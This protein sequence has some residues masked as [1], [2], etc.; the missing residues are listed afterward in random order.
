MKASSRPFALAPVALVVAGMF[1]AAPTLRAVAATIHVTT[2][3]QK[4]SSS[5]SGGCSLQEAIYSS[6]FAS[7][8]ALVPAPNSLI[9][10]VNTDCEAGSGDDTIVLMGGETYSMSDPVYDPYNYMGPTATPVI[11]SRIVIEANGATLVHASNAVSFR[12]FSIGS[13]SASRA[14]GTVPGAGSLDIRNAN[15]R[16][17]SVKGGDGTSGGGGGLGAGGAIYIN[18]GTL[19][20]ESTAFEAN[21]AFGGN[22]SPRVLIGS[23]GGGGGGLGGDGGATG[24][25]PMPGQGGGTGGGGGGARGSGADATNRFGGGGGGTASDGVAGQGG[26]LCGGNGGD[27]SGN[28]GADG[29]AGGGGGGG[30]PEGFLVGAGKGGDGGY[31]GGGGGG[32][33]DADGGNGGFGAGGGSSDRQTGGNGGFGGGGGSSFGQPGQALIPTYGGN[34]SQNNSGG[35]AGLGGAIFNHRGTVR[36]YNST[37]SGN[38]AQHGCKGG[39]CNGS[40]TTAQNSGDA[41]AAIFSLN[42]ALSIFSSTITGNQGT[43]TGAGVVAIGARDFD[44]LHAPPPGTFELRNTII[45]GNNGAQE[46]FW[47]GEA[48]TAQGSGNLIVNNGAAGT[49]CPGVVSSS[50]PQLGSLQ[51]NVPGVTKTMMIGDASPAYNAGVAY[52][53]AEIASAPTLATDQRG[54]SRPQFGSFDIGAYEVGC[55]TLAPPASFVQATDPNACNAIVTYPLPTANGACGTVSCS[56][57][58]GSVFALGPTSVACR[59]A[60]GLTAGFTIGVKDTQAPTIDPL[61][62]ARAAL[63]PIDHALVNVGLAGG[64]TSDNCSGSVTSVRVFANED[65]ET[66]TGDGVYSPDA[67]NVAIGT[68]RVRAERLDSGSGRVYLIV[69]TVTDASNNSAFRVANVVVPKSQST[70]DMKTVNNLAAAAV[71]YALSHNGSPPAGYFLVGDGRVIGPKQ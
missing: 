32:G 36:I 40:D 64:A 55:S 27:S 62:V 66:D 60:T 28:E 15:I 11:F 8:I 20:V 24:G 54:I 13:G 68:L 46:C 61:S 33:A 1:F 26:F 16:G 53:A 63:W 18:E 38:V 49:A 31:G 2:T 70:K 21:G 12:L 9:T 58:S 23:G 59:T 56:P 7:N 69:A 43:G 47:G 39:G 6:S 5:G 57:V 50:D 4:V 3:A 29:C 51:F 30:T 65:D 71:D 37:F 44:L 34:A 52:S 41:G 25:P 42:G 10:F 48:I 35:G 17:F 45:A 67:A 14:N 19:V 22:G